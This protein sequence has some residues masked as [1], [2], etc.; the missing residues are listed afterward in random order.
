MF[1]QAKPTLY[2]FFGYLLPGFVLLAAPTRW[3]VASRLSRRERLQRELDEIRP[4]VDRGR[5]AR[6]VV[7]VNDPRVEFLREPMSEAALPGTAKAVHGDDSSPYARRRLCRSNR[8]DEAPECL[9]HAGMM[10]TTVRV[11]AQE[12]LPDA[13]RTRRTWFA[14]WLSQP[15]SPL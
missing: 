5:P 2:D 11:R 10:A 3:L 6:E 12:E 14:G 7:G 15:H 8:V 1:N 9:V 4:P 13:R